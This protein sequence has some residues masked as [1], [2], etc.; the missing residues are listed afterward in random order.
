M[1]LMQTCVLWP[2]AGPAMHH[3]RLYEPPGV[4]PV[5]AMGRFFARNITY[6]FKRGYT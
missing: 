5:R 3:D 4:D 2:R 6:H 1:G